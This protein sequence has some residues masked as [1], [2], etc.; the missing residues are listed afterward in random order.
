MGGEDVLLLPRCHQSLPHN[1]VPPWRWVSARRLDTLCGVC[2]RRLDTLC[3]CQ[4]TNSGFRISVRPRK[5]VGEKSRKRSQKTSVQLIARSRLTT[6]GAAVVVY[7][8]L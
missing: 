1:G 8:R 2:A 6:T 5:N 7:Y 3:G 4:G